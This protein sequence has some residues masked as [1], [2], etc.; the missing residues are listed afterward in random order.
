MLPDLPDRL[1][2]PIGGYRDD[3]HEVGKKVGS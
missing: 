3:S 2:F 1:E